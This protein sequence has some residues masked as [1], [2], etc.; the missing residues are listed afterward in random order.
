ML[1]VTS[2]FSWLFAKVLFGI[3]TGSYPW[4][5]LVVISNALFFAGLM[6]FLSNFVKTERAAGALCWSLL[7]VLAC[8]SGIMFPIAIMPP[9]MVTITDM[10]PLKWSV[11]AMEIALWKEVSFSTMLLPVGIPLLSGIIL[12]GLSA[13]SFRWTENK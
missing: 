3:K 1:L 8:F 5:V 7:Q 11:N 6:T 9:W 12:F 13:Y 4:L 2:V 10:N